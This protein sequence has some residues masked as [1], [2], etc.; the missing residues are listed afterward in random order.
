MRLKNE[1]IEK[2]IKE[3]LGDSEK[4]SP[5]IYNK[6]VNLSRIYSHINTDGFYFPGQSKDDRLAVDLAHIIQ[7]V[8][9][10]YNTNL[11]TEDDYDKHIDDLTELRKLTNI[12]DHQ[13]GNTIDNLK[14]RK[15]DLLNQRLRKATISRSSSFSIVEETIAKKRKY[16]DATK[17]LTPPKKRHKF[18]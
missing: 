15:R 6:I 17:L 9:H 18:V 16:D 14:N 5:A 4:G 10:G 8:S 7:G 12:L 1:K 3:N 11:P 2:S 13:L